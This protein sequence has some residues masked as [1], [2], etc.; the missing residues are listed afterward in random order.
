MRIIPVTNLNIT[1]VVYV[2][3][4]RS[5]AMLISAPRDPME[6]DISIDVGSTGPCET[7][8][9]I[10]SRVLFTSEPVSGGNKPILLGTVV[11]KIVM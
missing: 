5:N 2:A 10:M 4:G 1:A 11:S 9:N 8:V 6:S 7:S 3:L